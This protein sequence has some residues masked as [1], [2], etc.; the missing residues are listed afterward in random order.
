MGRFQEMRTQE[1]NIVRKLAEMTAQESEHRW[2]ETTTEHVCCRGS[3]V[4]YRRDT[5]RGQGYWGGD[6]YQYM[7]HW[8]SKTLWFN[9]SLRTR[10]SL[11]VFG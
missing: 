5:N 4:I 8:D 10:H 9:R 3:N 2:G 6:C 1:E 11:G 7:K